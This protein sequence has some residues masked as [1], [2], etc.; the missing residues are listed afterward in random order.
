MWYDMSHPLWKEWEAG[1]YRMAVEYGV[2]VRPVKK[3][4]SDGDDFYYQIGDKRFDCLRNLRK[5]LE[6]KSF[7]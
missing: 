7:L 4:T 1:A 5:A 2:S 3:W 6:M